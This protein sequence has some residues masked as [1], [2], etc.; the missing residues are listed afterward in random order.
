MSESLTKIMFD[1]NVF[2][3]IIENRCIDELVELKSRNVEYL[4]TN[5]QVDEISVISDDEKTKRQKLFSYIVLLQ[6]R[7]I[8]ANSGAWGQSKWGFLTWTRNEEEHMI[9]DV[10][11]VAK[12]ENSSRDSLIGVTALKNA[13]IFVSNDEERTIHLKRIIASKGLKTKIMNFNEFSK[14]LKRQS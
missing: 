14:W 9:D 3:S 10:R 6:P 2:D 1:T 7:H 4:I 11:K 12:G 13:D 5:V 8:L